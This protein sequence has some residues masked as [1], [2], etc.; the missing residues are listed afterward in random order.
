MESNELLIEFAIN[1]IALIFHV[2]L[3]KKKTR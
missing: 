1:Y 2:R 3:K